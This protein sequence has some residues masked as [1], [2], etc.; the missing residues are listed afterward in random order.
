LLNDQWANEEIRRKIQ[1]FIE[2]NEN[3]HNIPEHLRYRKDCVK[4]KVY[5]CLHQRKQKETL[6]LIN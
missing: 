4:K 5:E 2:S 3:E 1:K 6:I